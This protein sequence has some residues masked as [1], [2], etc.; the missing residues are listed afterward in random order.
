MLGILAAHRP[1]AFGRAKAIGLAHGT[2]ALVFPKE[3]TLLQQGDIGNQ[4]R[5]HHPNYRRSSEV[6]ADV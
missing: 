5:L 6:K 3:H 2:V 4:H 1:W